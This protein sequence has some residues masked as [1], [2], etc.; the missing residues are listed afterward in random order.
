[1]RHKLL[2]LGLTVDAVDR[3]C[4]NLSF[5]IR[6]TKADVH[7][8]R[9]HLRQ[10]GVIVSKGFGKLVINKDAVVNQELVKVK[11]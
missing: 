1:M 10:R 4:S 6:C 7:D 11:P 8:I 2:E 3:I 5:K 9:H